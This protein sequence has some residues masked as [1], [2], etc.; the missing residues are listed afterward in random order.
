[1]SLGRSW[2]PILLGVACGCSQSLGIEDRE[3]VCHG[4]S[5]PSCGSGC[6]CVLM[7]GLEDWGM[8]ICGTDG[9]DSGET[10]GASDAEED[11]G[12]AVDVPVGELPETGRS[13][14]APCE[15]GEQCAIDFCMSE[16]F[17]SMFSGKDLPIPGGLC[18]DLCDDTDSCG[19]DGTCVSIRMSFLDTGL[20]LG[21]CLRE[22]LGSG[23][24]RAGYEC[25]ESRE[26]ADEVPT[27]GCMPVSLADLSRCGNRV[28]D[29]READGRAPCAHD[30]TCLDPERIRVV[31]RADLRG[32]LLDGNCDA[33]GP[34]HRVSSEPD[35]GVR[36]S[37]GIHWT[38]PLCTQGAEE[39]CCL[40]MSELESLNHALGDWGANVVEMF[41]DGT[42][43]DDTA[44]DSIFSAML[45]LP[46]LPVDSCGVG[47]RI[48]YKYSWG[49]H[50]E[51]WAGTEEWP[52]GMRLLELA[53][54]NGDGLVV[55]YDLFGDETANKDRDNLLGA[56]RGGCGTNYWEDDIHPGCAHD[57]R[58]SMV[59]SAADCVPDRWPSPGN[60]TPLGSTRQDLCPC[61]Q[62]DREE[63]CGSDRCW[64]DGCGPAGNE[65]L[66]EC[67]YGCDAATVKCL[68]CVPSCAGKTCG[69]DG[70]GGSCGG[71]GAAKV[72]DGSRCVGDPCPSGFVPVSCGNFDLRDQGVSG[73]GTP[74]DGV[75]HHVVISR[76][77][78]MKE[79]EVT[80]EE[81]LAVMGTAPSFNHS[82]P[83]NCP[84][85]SVNWWEALS[86]CNALSVREG[87]QPCYS[88]T[89]CTGKAGEGLKCEGMGF[90]GL[91]CFGYRLPTSAEWEYAARAGT[92]GWTYNGTPDADHRQCERP[93][94]VLDPI[95]WYR[96]N[97]CS[98]TPP[99]SD[100]SGGG[101]CS[102]HPV[103]TRNANGW[104]LYDML[105]NVS[106][107][108]CDDHVTPLD[109]EL[110]PVGRIEVEQDGT[111]LARGG[112]Y[113]EDAWQARAVLNNTSYGINS[114]SR[115]RGFRPVRT[116]LP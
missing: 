60:V 71:C 80:Q 98:G 16:D 62:D 13:V 53:D 21:L 114:D 113:L 31:F 44:G 15:R 94:P 87:L 75:P 40:T 74:N 72:C 14:G 38:T 88:L 111:R 76:S 55:R 24:C 20:V 68:P 99:A 43:G 97:S 58:E 28:C 1:M 33:L 5:D 109:N 65:T 8:C 10:G 78:C 116:I 26:S 84:V 61:H 59:A 25:F 67:R 69:V 30:C 110:D 34:F 63:C 90:A 12:S 103:A 86:Y 64:I 19:D 23:N 108:T 47:V 3:F 70:C 57:T 42:H 50:D 51:A 6:S 89:G 18:T 54:L 92:D 82:C 52:D 41:D 11:P 48:G 29:P 4:P 77:F 79:T 22:C 66:E 102:T 112:N 83:G 85:E 107:W 104:G 35:R 96:G 32:Y 100:C 17:F 37:G 46:W 27:F 91:T 9:S 56:S 115:D 45:E 106:E 101:G 73:S 93:N 39:P 2:W 95:A 105:G 7:L 49:G 36:L 81:W